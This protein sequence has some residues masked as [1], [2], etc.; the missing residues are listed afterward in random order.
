MAKLI[1]E[2]KEDRPIVLLQKKVELLECVLLDYF[3]DTLSKE[4]LYQKTSQDDL[5]TWYETPLGKEEMEE[6]PDDVG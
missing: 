1:G 3:S 5:A 6:W 2:L 4:A